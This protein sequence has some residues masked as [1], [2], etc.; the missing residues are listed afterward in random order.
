M[1]NSERRKGV[2]SVSVSAFED[3]T[4]AEH[5]SVT[6]LIQFFFKLP[7]KCTFKLVLARVHVVCKLIMQLKAVVFVQCIG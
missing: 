4:T 1:S 7:N 2:C 3:L 5:Q 6:V